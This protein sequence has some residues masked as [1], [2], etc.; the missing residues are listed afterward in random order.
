MLSTVYIDERGPGLITA[1][2][3]DFPVS[4]ILSQLW[5]VNCHLPSES[6]CAHLG[7]QGVNHKK[8]HLH[9]QTANPVALSHYSSIFNNMTGNPQRHK[10]WMR[11]DKCDPNTSHMSG[12]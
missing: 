5:A 4:T 6:R 7:P 1:R 11:S 2:Q 9:D 10:Q 12:K 3:Q 8:K